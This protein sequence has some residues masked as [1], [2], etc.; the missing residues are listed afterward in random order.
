MSLSESTV[1]FEQP[2]LRRKIDLLRG[3]ASGLLSGVERFEEIIFPFPEAAL[4]Y[5]LPG[6]PGK[7]HEKGYVVQGTEFESENFAH[8][9]QMA[10]VSFCVVSANMVVESLINGCEV[11]GEPG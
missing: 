6:G 2:R 9:K 4:E 3:M 7:P 5:L 10:D 8:I 1:F 11:I